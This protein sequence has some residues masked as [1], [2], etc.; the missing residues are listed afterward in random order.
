MWLFNDLLEWMRSLILN[1][2]NISLIFIRYLVIFIL[3]ILAVHSISRIWKFN[4]Y[5]SAE[6]YIRRNLPIGSSAES[7]IMFLENKK[8]TYNIIDK[9]NIVAKIDDVSWFSFMG[10]MQISIHISFKFEHNHLY[11][12]DFEKGILA[13]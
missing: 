4:S 13:P 9:E 12:Y 3:I 5:H 1:I 11:K 10:M 6:T 7:V 2:F 8:I